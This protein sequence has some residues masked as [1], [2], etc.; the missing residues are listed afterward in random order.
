V[1]FDVVRHRRAGMVSVSL[2]DDAAAALAGVE[3]AEEGLLADAV[4]A[5]P[6][7]I[8]VELAVLLGLW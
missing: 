2:Y 5:T 6:A 1:S 8:G 4:R 3:I 7:Q